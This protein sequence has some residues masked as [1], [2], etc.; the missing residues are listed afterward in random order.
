MT[1][2]LYLGLKKEFSCTADMFTVALPAPVPDGVDQVPLGFVMIRAFDL[3]ADLHD[4]AS[5]IGVHGH[6]L[7]R[8]D[9][10]L[11]FRADGFVV[12]VGAES[13]WSTCR[14]PLAAISFSH[15]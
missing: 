11:P 6:A 10:R 7:P 2:K 1:P 9:V 3:L 5:E 13:P 4:E 8:P 15:C 12:T 14:A